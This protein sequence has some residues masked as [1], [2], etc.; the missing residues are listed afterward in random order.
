MILHACTYLKVTSKIIKQDYFFAIPSSRMTRCGTIYL[1]TMICSQIKW[2]TSLFWFSTEITFFDFVRA[3]SIR[4]WHAS[5]ESTLLSKP[6]IINSFICAFPSLVLFGY[7]SYL[8]YSTGLLKLI[9]VWK[10]AVYFF[11]NIC[12]FL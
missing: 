6:A 5:I 2:S 12:G 10:I 9:K 11:R 8:G 1:L 3:F 7:L 4:I